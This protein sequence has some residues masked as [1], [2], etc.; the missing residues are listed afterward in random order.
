MLETVSDSI[1]I[2]DRVY[3]ENKNL[4][5]NKFGT[6]GTLLSTLEGQSFG[7]IRS[8][9]P[10]V[11]TTSL[12]RGMASRHLAVLWGG[13]NIQ[14]IVNGTFDLGLI[15]NSFDKVGLYRNGTS[16]VTGNASMAGAIRLDNSIFDENAT[17]LKI[18]F[19]STKNKN[20]SLSNKLNH[21]RYTH[22]LAV[23]YID[24]EN[25]YSYFKNNQKQTQKDASFSMLDINYQFSW[26]LSTKINI[27]G[28]VWLQDADRNIPPTKTSVA[29]TQEQKDSNYRG[30]LHLTYNVSDKSRF[31]FRTAYFN[32]E[33][34]YV[35]PG[36]FSLANADITNLALD[37]LY[38]GGLSMSIQY[39]R[40]MVDASF[41][42]PIH[43]RNTTAFLL[44]WDKQVGTIKISGSIRPEWVEGDFQ[45]VAV[46]I[47]AKKEFSKQLGASIS[48]QK[49]YTLPSFNDLYWP[50]GGNANL[51]T[52]RSHEFDIGFIY[53]SGSP[54]Q[55]IVEMN[56][57]FN[58]IDD[59][60]QWTPVEG[61]FQP[62]NQRKVRSLGME[63]KAEQKF[64]LRNDY[65]LKLR[66]MYSFTDSRLL[67][68]YLNMEHNG[69]K[70]IFV[71]AHKLNGRVSLI[72]KSWQLHLIPLYYSK[73][74]D[75][76]DNSSY[77]PGFFVMDIEFLKEIKVRK[78]TINLSVGIENSMNNDYEN[79]RF[80]PMPLRLFRFGLN[81]KI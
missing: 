5:D 18:G 28:G 40:D 35:A 20:I 9:G 32:E 45:P 25:E 57:F 71:P 49:G 58:L 15:S 54:T 62:V 2:L 50:T 19:S 1:E 74:F 8:G 39:R 68:H 27:G 64:K 4:L 44:N 53:T 46:G 30:F 63:L 55:R 38:D 21:K 11:L 47:I 17:L 22:H 76:V 6:Q 13:F 41:F 43:T 60:I 42:D 61:F 65:V 59:W 14:S 12:N 29:I 80:F 69:K 51:K 77:V 79:I 37:Y 72:R 34:E 10:A 23:T 73:R 52:E 7:A 75:T 33:I 48:Y 36:I 56:L 24:D 26:I 16:V 3:G 66:L 67:E 31:K 81:F 78:K 70:S